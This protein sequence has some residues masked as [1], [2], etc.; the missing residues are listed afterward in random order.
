MVVMLSVMV[1]IAV[2]DAAVQMVRAIEDL[3]GKGKG[4]GRVESDRGLS[5]RGQP[6]GRG[7]DV[8]PFGGTV[9][10]TSELFMGLAATVL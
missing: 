2:V 10:V 1:L 3:E 4:R 5:N 9:E 6:G 8:S 7:V